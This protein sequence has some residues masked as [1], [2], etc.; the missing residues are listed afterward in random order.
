M[1][2]L[3]IFVGWLS[4][5]VLHLTQCFGIL[6]GRLMFSVILV[7]G[8]SLLMCSPPLP[9]SFVRASPRPIRPQFR[10]RTQWPLELWY[11]RWRGYYMSSYLGDGHVGSVPGPPPPRNS[12]LTGIGHERCIF[13]LFLKTREPPLILWLSALKLTLLTFLI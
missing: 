8:L 6:Y 12:S 1:C 11:H 2:Q 13:S 4:F 10:T 7:L 9:G 3:M 5:L